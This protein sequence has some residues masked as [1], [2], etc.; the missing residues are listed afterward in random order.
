MPHRA[1]MPAPQPLLIDAAGHACVAWW[2][3]PAPAA[4]AR[5]APA[6]PRG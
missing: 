5:V 4:D 6:L 2:H 1:A 3:A